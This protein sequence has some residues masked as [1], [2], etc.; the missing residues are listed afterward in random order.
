MSNITNESYGCSKDKYG[1][2]FYID[3]REF[4]FRRT[5]GLSM[6]FPVREMARL[7]TEL[8]AYTGEDNFVFEENCNYGL[9]RTTMNPKDAFALLDKLKACTRM[10]NMHEVS[11]YENLR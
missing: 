11:P 10:P 3:G 5:N 8:L 4:E 1:L 2:Y 9:K 6:F 7:Y